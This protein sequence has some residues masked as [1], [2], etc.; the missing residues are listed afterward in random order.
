MPMDP[1][2]AFGG[3][4][5]GGVSA[6]AGGARGACADAAPDRAGADGQSAHSTHAQSANADE[7]A[8]APRNPGYYGGHGNGHRGCD[9]RG[10][11]GCSGVGETA[12]AQR[13]SQRRTIRKSLEA[14]WQA[15]HLFTLKQSRE[16]LTHYQKQIEA[17]DE[18]IEKL[19][20]QFEPRVDPENQPLPPDRKRKQQSRKKQAQMKNPKTGFDLRKE[21]Y[22][23]F[24]VDLTQVPGL[25]LMVLT[26]FSEIG[27]DMSKWPTAGQFAS[28]LGL[29]PDND[30]TGGKV[31]WRRMRKVKNRAGTLF[32]LAAHSLHHEESALG[33][34][35]RRMKSKLGPAG[36][37]TATAHKIAI[38]FYTMV[39]NQVEYDPAI[40][41]KRDSQRAKRMER[42]LH[43]QAQ[44]MGYKLVP[45]EE[46]PAA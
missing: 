6:G 32:R 11:A 31:R 12:H 13:Q 38:V 1:V 36:A 3:A 26:L 28:W 2:S 5:A 39:K 4:A 46:K 33:D 44:Q 21:A 29:C 7:C 20:L 14:N 34:Y 30:I 45:V 10:R 24:G 15:E 17:C 8:V 25:M 37:T 40:W 23:L 18:E 19:L 35:L 43:R 42:K 41:A 16:S 22:K 27:R 9:S